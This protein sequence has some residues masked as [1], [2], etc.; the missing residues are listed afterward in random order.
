MVRTGLGRRLVQRPSR[1]SVT[2]DSSVFSEVVNACG[3]GSLPLA[4]TLPDGTVVAGTVDRLLVEE[5]RVSVVDFKTG[6]VPERE[7]AI[8]ADHRAQMAA[9]IAA[10]RVIFPGRD[11]RASLLYTAGPTLFE[12]A[13]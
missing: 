5:D 8:P 9:Y 4:A 1:R 3:R 6:K 12:L 13:A 2:I 11:V 10:L 7:D